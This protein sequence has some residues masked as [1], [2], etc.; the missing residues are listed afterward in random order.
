MLDNCLPPPVNSLAKFWGISLFLPYPKLI[1]LRTK[2]E[3]RIKNY[4]LRITN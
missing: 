2:Y 3:L 1:F 4:E